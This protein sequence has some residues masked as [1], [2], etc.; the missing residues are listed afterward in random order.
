MG[1]E[2]ALTR[3]HNDVLLAIDDSSCVILMLLD[4]STAFDTVDHDIL[5]GRLEYRFGITGKALPWLT[6]YMN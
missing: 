1:T 2:T 6:S 5:L 3:T 4:L